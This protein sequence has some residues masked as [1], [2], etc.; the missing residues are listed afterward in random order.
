[1]SQGTDYE[2]DEVDQENPPK[3]FQDLL[4]DNI[5]PVLSTP[6]IL[7]RLSPSSLLPLVTHSLRS[8]VPR[9]VMRGGRDRRELTTNRGAE[10]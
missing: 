9:V 5:L 1:M 3:E 8:L 10:E 6:H 2:I 4:I 7:A